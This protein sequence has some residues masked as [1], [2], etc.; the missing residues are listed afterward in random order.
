MALEVLLW[1]RFGKREAVKKKSLTLGKLC[2]KLGYED[3]ESP[4]RRAVKLRN[5]AIHHPDKPLYFDQ[6]AEA[7][8]VVHH[9]FVEDHATV[10]EPYEP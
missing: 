4:I 8:H 9:H 3:L 2:E 5:R 1:K 7:F 6:I 10:F